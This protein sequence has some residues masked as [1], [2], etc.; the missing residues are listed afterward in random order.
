MIIFF[1]RARAQ[2]QQKFS[3][4]TTMSNRSTN[5]SGV[6]QNPRLVPLSGG[7]TQ[8]GISRMSNSNIVRQTNVPQIVSVHSGVSAFHHDKLDEEDLFLPADS[9]ETIPNVINDEEEMILSDPIP[10]ALT[11]AAPN[12]RQIVLS[13]PTSSQK[14][15]NKLPATLT[16]TKLPTTKNNL[17]S[18]QTTS[19]RIVS[20]VLPPKTNVN[21]QVKYTLVK[22]QQPVTMQSPSKRSEPVVQKA[23][24]AKNIQQKIIPI[25]F[26]SKATSSVS[27]TQK[28]PIKPVPVSSTSTVNSRNNSPPVRVTRLTALKEQKSVATTTTTKIAEPVVKAKPGPKFKMTNYENGSRNKSI[29]PLIGSSSS[30]MPPVTTIPAAESDDERNESPSEIENN[31]EEVQSIDMQDPLDPLAA[32]A[33]K[34]T[35][36]EVVESSDDEPLSNRL[37]AS[38]MDSFDSLK[39]LSMSSPWEIRK[40]DSNTLVK[41]HKGKLMNSRDMQSCSLYIFFFI[42]SASKTANYN[43]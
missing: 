10:V 15:L 19:N 26:Q 9:V 23:T 5:V 2:V 40:K 41:E 12:P 4:S 30:F 28:L 29:D 20:K 39:K 43:F 21:Q 25:H 6:Q 24:L 8:R 32:V 3:P 22:P 13:K 42:H 27:I 16:V 11:K 17:H 7:F 35:T 33:S 36:L 31:E 1:F 14:I 34:E 18:Y 38:K 37:P